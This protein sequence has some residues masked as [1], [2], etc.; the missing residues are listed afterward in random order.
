MYFFFREVL[1][2]PYVLNMPE[3]SDWKDC[4]LS[5][6]EEIELC[7]KFREKFKPF[8]FTLDD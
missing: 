4:M 7:Q 6:E 2:C 5:K 8:D 3:K 1:A